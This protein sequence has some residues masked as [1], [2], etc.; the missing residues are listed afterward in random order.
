MTL[1]CATRMQ[2]STRIVVAPL[3]AALWPRAETDVP[4]SPEGETLEVKERWGIHRKAPAFDQLE[5]KTEMFETGIKV[6][7]LLAP[8][9]KGG[10]VG[11]FGGAGVGK[12][13]NMMELINNIATEHSGLSVFAG[14]GERTREG[15]DFY[16]EMQE[17]G[18]LEKV[19]RIEAGASEASE[20][21]SAR[22]AAA[23]L[24]LS[25]QA[26]SYASANARRLGFEN[27]IK[28]MQ[29]DWA[30]GLVETFDLILCNPPYVPEGAEVVGRVADLKDA[31]HFAGQ[32]QV[33]LE[34]KPIDPAVADGRRGVRDAGE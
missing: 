25:R 28:L 18:V 21:L 16:H 1:A 15:N 23:E 34:L 20:R 19:A 11:L 32:P 31:G 13:V 29:G 2:S 6:I 10:K 27:R 22:Q 5:S 24:G 7:D 17:S 33:A 30:K 14:V 26:L 4:S 9:A 3:R 8:Y 12:T